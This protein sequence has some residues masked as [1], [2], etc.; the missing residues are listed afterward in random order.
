MAKLK[1]VANHECESQVLLAFM[2]GRST[3]EDITEATGYSI[4]LVEAAINQLNEMSMAKD[5]I[6]MFDLGGK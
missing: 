1:L 3:V 6:P 2:H 4:S 5:G